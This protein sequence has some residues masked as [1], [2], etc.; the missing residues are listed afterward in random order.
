MNN[1]KLEETLGRFFVT[2]KFKKLAEE[3]GLT[4]K[5]VAKFNR[6]IATAFVGERVPPQF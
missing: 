4:G 5:H 3:Q 6:E 1:P 2:E